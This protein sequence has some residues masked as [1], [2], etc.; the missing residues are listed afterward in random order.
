MVL[1]SERQFEIV[2][3]E[4]LVK[5]LELVVSDSMY[6]TFTVALSSCSEVDERFMN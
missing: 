2:G 5:G 6:T 3:F 4:S 1:A